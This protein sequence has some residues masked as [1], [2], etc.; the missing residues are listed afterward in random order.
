[1]AMEVALKC[2][3]IIRSTFNGNG[4]G[5]VP[6]TSPYSSLFQVMSKNTAIWM[7]SMHLI[8]RIF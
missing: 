3:I 2:T 5:A 6:P 4:G 8:L 7:F 1:M